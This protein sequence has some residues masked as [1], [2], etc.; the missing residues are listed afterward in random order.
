[1]L[2]PP[3]PAFATS[4]IIGRESKRTNEKTMVLKDKTNTK[5]KKKTKQTKKKNN[6]NGAAGYQGR[7][8]IELR[9]DAGTDCQPIKHD[10]ANTP[11]GS[12]T[13]SGLSRNGLQDRTLE[14]LITSSF[15]CHSVNYLLC[16][17]FFTFCRERTGKFI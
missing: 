5:A 6:N 3:A 14:S 1:M 13:L 15:K 4:Q 16:V 17:V 9:A 2:L 11:I 12:G 8:K 10:L 7:V